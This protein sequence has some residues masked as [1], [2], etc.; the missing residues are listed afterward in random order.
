MSNQ[1]A[2]WYLYLVRCQDK[3][4]YTGISNQV[5]ERI[6]KHNQGKGAAYTAQRRPVVLIYQEEHPDQNSARKREAQIKKWS[7]QKKEMLIFLDRTRDKQGFPRQG[8]G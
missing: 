8:S 7:R 1:L 3:S 5:E 6:K 4:L 2:P